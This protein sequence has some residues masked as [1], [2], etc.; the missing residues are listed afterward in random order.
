MKEKL[1]VLRALIEEETIERYNKDYPNITGICLEKSTSVK[2]K[3]GSKYVKVDV[4]ES[5]K[6]MVEVSSGNIFGIKGYGVIHRGHYYGNLDTINQYY[7]GGY[8]ASMKPRY[9]LVRAEAL[10]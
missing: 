6:Y 8:I 7:W 5:G 10:V 4:G 1:E 9:D 3:P 2:I